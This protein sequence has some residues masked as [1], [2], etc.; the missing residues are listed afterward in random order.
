VILVAT[1]VTLWQTGVFNRWVDDDAA[2]FI[3][4][5]PTVTTEKATERKTAEA[6]ATPTESATEEISG[7]GENPTVSASTATPVPPTETATP[8]PTQTPVTPSPSPTPV[9]TPTPAPP[10]TCPGAP[11]QRVEIG[12]RAWVCTAYDK[13]IVRLQPGLESREIARLE[14]GAYVTIFAGPECADSWSWWRIRTGTGASGWVAEGG[15]EVD[16]YFICPL[17]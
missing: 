5:V 16:P 1:V 4:P 8:S 15:D 3:E 9:P 17:E 7:V 13:L 14:P 2:R 10:S 11:P 12:D 6:T